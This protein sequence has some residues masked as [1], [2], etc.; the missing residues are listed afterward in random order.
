MSNDSDD[1]VLSFSDLLARQTLREHHQA[2][3]TTFAIFIGTILILSLAIALGSWVIY[4]Y[5]LKKKSM[6]VDK[7]LLHAVIGTL[8]HGLATKRLEIEITRVRE[9][10]TPY[11]TQRHDL[12]VRSGAREQQPD[13]ALAQTG[14]EVH[15]T[16]V[17]EMETA[18]T[19][20][21]NGHP[22]PR[23]DSYTEITSNG[24]PGFNG[25]YPPTRSMR[26]DTSR[27]RS[28][29]AA[30]VLCSS[31]F[32]SDNDSNTWNPDS[33]RAEEQTNRCRS[34]CCGNYCSDGHM[35]EIV[36]EVL[37]FAGRELKPHKWAIAF[38]YIYFFYVTFIVLCWFLIILTDN[39][40]YRKT[41][42]CNDINVNSDRYGC[43]FVSNSSRA[44]CVELKL[45]PDVNKI[46]VICYLVNFE[47]TMALGVATGF[48]KFLTFVANVSFRTTVVLSCT[49]YG[50]IFVV[51]LQVLGTVVLLL[52][53]CLGL[54]GISVNTLNWFVYGFIPMR[55]V[56]LVMV[57]FLA[58]A[59][60]CIPWWAV[61]CS[62]TELKDVGINNVIKKNK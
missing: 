16:N 18:M 55:L 40:L 54:G 11:V 36:H 8:F 23:S 35:G 49:K 12:T 59:V 2:E 20:L 25:T 38:T 57:I 44:D 37:L 26:N 1:G 15:R 43:Y 41:T 17:I 29:S 10:V 19:N 53:F 46:D 3:G 24:H 52:I 27:P 42:T 51:G 34:L 58:I 32:L 47:P 45:H 4:Y 31:R 6:P 28:A 21:S 39:L 22:L 50:R 13:N 56:M 33:E 7:N 9:N 48:A 60:A 30:L 62:C 61:N 14:G 5:G